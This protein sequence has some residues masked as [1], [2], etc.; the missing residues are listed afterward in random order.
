MLVGFSGQDTPKWKEAQEERKMGSR[1]L[2]AKIWIKIDRNLARQHAG[3][4]GAR[5]LT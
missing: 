2:K 4:K 3:G 5:S 1:L